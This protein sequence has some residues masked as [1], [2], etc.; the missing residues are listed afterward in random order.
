MYESK[1]TNNSGSMREKSRTLQIRFRTYCSKL[2]YKKRLKRT[3][4][5]GYRHKIERSKNHREN[6]KKAPTSHRSVAL[7]PC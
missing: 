6:A 3:P 4:N 5:S 1:E 7:I 2:D